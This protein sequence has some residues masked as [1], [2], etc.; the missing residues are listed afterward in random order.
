MN[1]KHTIKL[2]EG[3]EIKEARILVNSIF[4]NQT[5]IE[6]SSFYV[7]KYRE[8]LITKILLFIFG[9][10]SLEYWGL[11]HK[12][13]VI[14]TIGL[15]SLSKDKDSYWLGWY[16]M[17]PSYHGRGFGKKLLDFAETKAKNDNKKYI[18]LYTS[19]SPA[20]KVANIIYEK[21]GYKI[22]SKKRTFGHKNNT[23][24]RKKDL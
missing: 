12:G 21:R 3:D 23:I 11:I 8:F 15:Y 1:E 18:K 22:T 24:F 6:R 7:F 19:D 9:Y 14:G 4:Y 10:S 17:E 20:L 2:L 13:K 5:I 16:S